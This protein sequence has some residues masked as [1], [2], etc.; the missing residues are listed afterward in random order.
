MTGTTTYTITICVP[1]SG[2][3]YGPCSWVPLFFFSPLLQPTRELSNLGKKVS[4]IF[5]SPHVR[6]FDGPASQEHHKQCQHL[7]ALLLF[8]ISHFTFFLSLCQYFSC[9]LR[10]L[11]CLYRS[12]LGTGT[13][14]LLFLLAVYLILGGV[15]ANGPVL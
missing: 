5:D 10:C 11:V 14:G 13:Q 9:Y 3:L 7:C 8:L 2:V 1:S 4:G 15:D 6:T 12:W